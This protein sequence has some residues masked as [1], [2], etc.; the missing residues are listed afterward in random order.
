MLDCVR[1]GWQCFTMSVLVPSV[2][3][4]RGGVWVSFGSF[5]H[6]LCE[7][8]G[9]LGRWCV[10]MHPEIIGCVVQRIIKQRNCREL[11]HGLDVCVTKEAAVEVG[12]KLWW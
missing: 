5:P 3:E 6:A 7:H 1:Y 11:V 9:Y 10:R 2:V 12:K 4:D 8:I